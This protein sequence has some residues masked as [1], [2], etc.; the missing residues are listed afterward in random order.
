MRDFTKKPFYLSESDL[1]WVES[2]FAGMSQDEKLDQVF[3]DMLWNLPPKEVAEQ[4][5]QNNFGGY[6]YNNQSAAKIREQNEA[7]QKNAKIPALIA[8]N[9]E[10]GGNGACS[11]GT[12]IGEEIAVAAT[13]DVKNA[14]ALGY[15]GCK[16]A[17]AVGCSWTF[18]PI[19]DIDV[20][21]RNCI[22]P[23]RC[24]GQDPDTVLKMSLAYMEGAHKAGVACCMKHFPGDGCDERD[25]HLCTTYNDRSCEEWDATYGKI[26]RGMIEAGVPSVMVGHIALPAYSRKLRPGIQDKDILPATVAPELLQDL[27]RDELGFNGLV[28]TDAT[29]MVGITGRMQRR[30]FLP[31]MLM[32]GCDM[33]LYYR[34][35]NED[36]GYLKDALKDGR[37]TQ[38]RLDEAVRTVLAFK[39][40]CKL[41]EK[42]KNGTLVPPAEELSVIGCA[43]H[44]QAA[45]AIIDQSITLVK[46]SRN[47]LPI[48]PQTHKRI[49]IYPVEGGGLMEKLKR[50]KKLSDVLA[51]QLRAEGF[52]VEIYKLNPFKY[53]SPRGVNGKKALASMTIAEFK[54]RYDAAIVISHVAPFSTT[55]GR[56]IR[57]TMPMGPEIPWYASEVPTVAISTAWPFHLLDLPMVPIYINTYN[58]SAEALRQT[59]QKIM[60]R[61]E[62]KGVSPVDAS[63]G[64][65]DTML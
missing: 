63:C 4:V 58:R 10:S 52:E 12:M 39:A 25:Q 26:Y 42:Q 19:V 16:E 46:N 45:A 33:I 14:Y 20:N 47:Q 38:E 28:I 1:Q 40:Y 53:L 23:T 60:G 35:K 34:D 27:L 8:A 15:Y 24:F 5:Q 41:H 21:W 55:N 65:S 32:S 59:V 11:D 13:G 7:I 56:S 51:E 36:L 57:W 44:K 48:T 31:R 64:C 18:A 37:L 30:E 9:I 6:R 50:K 29:H 49:V 43:E 3:V 61:S 22:I 54:S 2:T 17:A 62:F